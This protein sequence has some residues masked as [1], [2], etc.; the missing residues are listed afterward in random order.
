MLKLFAHTI[1][2]RF[3]VHISTPELN[4]IPWLNYLIQV[5]KL[6][7]QQG[8]FISL[9]I[10]L[11]IGRSFFF[12]FCKSS[13]IFCASKTQLKLYTHNRPQTLNS[14]VYLGRIYVFKI[15]VHEFLH[16]ESTKVSQSTHTSTL[17]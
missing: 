1:K 16:D 8:K 7:T 9:T 14:F 10:L 13:T 12:P 5:Y 6:H 2:S 4:A 11:F 3:K 15:D 17:I